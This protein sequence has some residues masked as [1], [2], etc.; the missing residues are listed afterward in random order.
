MKHILAILSV[1]LVGA[2]VPAF[3]ANYYDTYANPT[4]E[5]STSSV[6]IP[7]WN[8]S[9][10]YTYETTTYQNYQVVRSSYLDQGLWHDSYYKFRITGNNVD[11]YITDYLDTIDGNP[12]TG[13]SDNIDALKNKGI[14]QIGYRYLDSS[15]PENIG[16]TVST[17]LDVAPN[18]AA[19]YV[20]AQDTQNNWQQTLVEGTLDTIDTDRYKNAYVV[21]RNQY[22]LGNFNEGDEIEIYL[23]ADGYGEAW[24]NTT[25]YMGGYGAGVTDAS[26]R[27]AA[28]QLGLGWNE[29]RAAAPLAS[30]DVGNG[31]RVFYGVYGETVGKPLPGGTA[32][33]VVAGLFALGFLVLRRRKAIAA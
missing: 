23:Q 11:L 14:T 31:H 17:G 13:V 32:V 25:N 3:A 22:Y 30:L 7:E 20:F 27:L 4:V 16:K 33:Y 19:T 21:T 5:T 24:S 6:W 29:T 2:A 10:S 26:D 28:Y 15:N 12:Q 1:A 9:G 8:R 18:S